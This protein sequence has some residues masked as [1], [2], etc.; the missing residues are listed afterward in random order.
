[1]SLNKRFTLYLCLLAALVVQPVAA[2]NSVPATTGLA[3]RLQS[4]YPGTR[5]GEVNPTPW[6]GVYEVAMGE[7]LA[8]V[9]ATGQYF[10]FGHFF[11]MQAQRDLTAE[12]KDTIGRIEFASLPLGDAIKEVRGTGARSFAI[13]ADPDCPYCRRLEGDIRSL[14]DVTIYTFLMPIPSLHPAA[15]A[16]AIGIW[17][18]TDQIAAWHALMWDGQNPAARDCPH[19]VD[20]N[21]E[22]AEQLGISGTPTLI[23]AD[24]RI[25]P[26]VASISQ[27]EVWLG[28]S[29]VS[30]TDAPR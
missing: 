2:Q 22:L 7:N 5:F 28:H 10:L 25:L 19:P 20:R 21:M 6:P 29:A 23:A 13:F 26:G 1:M 4:L 8:Y 17:C 15:R 11:D 14:T 18:S 27:I 24:G 9:D 3:E 16:K 12:R 30:V